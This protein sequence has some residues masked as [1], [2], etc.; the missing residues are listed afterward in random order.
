MMARVKRDADRDRGPLAGG[1][2]DAHAAAQG[3][4]VPL[5]HV[6]AHAPA[7]HVGDL[8]GRGETGG[9]DEH[10]GVLVGQDRVGGDDALFER[11]G[12]DP[13]RVDSRAVVNDADQDLAARMF[14]REIDPPFR[15]L[16]ALDALLRRFDAVVDAVAEQMDQGIVQAFNDRLVQLGFGPKVSRAICLPS[17]WDRSRTRRLNRLNVVPV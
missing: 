13:L 17:S 10:Q 4:D 14:G 3:V 2:F 12:L 1:A 9:E 11:L 8:L 5:D 15:T 7:R 6:H 16:A